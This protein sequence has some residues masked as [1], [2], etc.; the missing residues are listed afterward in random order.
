MTGFWL[1]W[2][3]VVVC[4]LSLVAVNG[5]YSLGVACGLLIAVAS[6]VEAQALR[7][8]A[9]VI[10]AWM[11]QS[12]GSV[13]MAHALSCSAAYGIFQTRGQTSIPCIGRGILNHWSIREIQ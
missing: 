5:G 9:S 7:M 8:Q 13:V 1:C 6:L 2:V 12:A 10:A 3:F 4:G 11:T